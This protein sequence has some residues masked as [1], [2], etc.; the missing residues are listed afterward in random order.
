VWI[1]RPSEC[2]K[3]ALGYD[4]DGADFT[5]VKNR[6]TYEVLAS[7]F[8]LDRD[9]AVAAIGAA[10]HFLDIGGIPVPDA[11][12]VEAML[13]GAREKARSDDAL[14]GEATRVFDLLYSGLTE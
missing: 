1:S 14:L 5:H 4:Y 2:P 9:P 8:G 13:K 12:M 3:N 11:K 10:V 7:S 6:V